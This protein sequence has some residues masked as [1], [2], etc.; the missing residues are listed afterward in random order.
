MTGP[1]ITD[2]KIAN[3]A[4]TL[5]AWQKVHGRH[6]LPWQNTRDPYKV[7]LSEIMLQ[8]T[9]VTTVKA[10][11]DR[12]LKAYPTVSDL[13]SASLD[14][15]LGLWS[16]LGY[17]SR[18][19]NLHLCAQKIQTDHKGRFPQDAATLQSLP[20]IGPSTASAIASL[21]Y[22]E[23]VAIMDG[24]VKRVLTRVLG[25]EADLSKAT[26][27]RELLQ[28][29]NGLLPAGTDQQ[30]WKD[31]PHYTQGI[32]DL[33][34]GL[35]STRQPQCAVCPVNKI[36]E[37]HSQDRPSDFPIKSRKLKRSSEVLWMLLAKRG[38]GAV[39]LTQ[40]P[41]TGVWA[42][43]YCLP[44]F[45]NYDDILGLVPKRLRSAL[46]EGATFKHVLTHKDLHIHPLYLNLPAKAQLIEHM[47]PG[48]SLG[49]WVEANEWPKLGLPAPVRNLLLVT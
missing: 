16:G 33:G 2:N 13:A 6:D 17:Y 39:Y 10:Y 21:C 26:N 40:R 31:M 45:G 4:T 32:M 24:N 22:G 15:V 23:R 46:N 37:A 49:R 47:R 48:Q 38:D 7:W 5:I 14:E 30:L 12:F 19:R 20:G 42:G 34:A 3:F 9:Q 29:A 27:V 25:Y 44:S 8:Q 36:C 28:L 18:A 11:F 41:A 1:A 35:C 43:L